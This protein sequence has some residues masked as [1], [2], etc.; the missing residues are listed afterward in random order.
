M[1]PSCPFRLII[2][3][4]SPLHLRDHLV[5]CI[6]VSRVVCDWLLVL[7]NLA[8]AWCALSC[9]C[10]LS[11]IRGSSSC[12]KNFAVIFGSAVLVSDCVPGHCVARSRLPRKNCR[13][14]RTCPKLLETTVVRG[15]ITTTRY[16]RRLWCLQ[17]RVTRRTKKVAR[18]SPQGLDFNSFRLLSC[19]ITAKDTEFSKESV[20]TRIMVS[21]SDVVL[22]ASLSLNF[23]SMS[24]PSARSQARVFLKAFWTRLQGTVVA[25]T[26]LL[27]PTTGYHKTRDSHVIQKRRSLFNASAR[28]QI[29]VL[30]RLGFF[31]NFFRTA[32]GKLSS[33]NTSAPSPQ[34]YIMRRGI[35]TTRLVQGH[36][37]KAAVSDDSVCTKILVS[38][39]CTSLVSM[40]CRTGGTQTALLVISEDLVSTPSDCGRAQSLQKKRRCMLHV[41][42]MH[43]A[44]VSQ[45]RTT[46][47][48]ALQK[49]VFGFL[50]CF[51]WAS[52][53]R[54]RDP[55]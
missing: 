32:C 8:Q 5:K 50:L 14:P 37:V 33:S 21:P 44:C 7:L 55:C 29:V 1:V 10:I 51:L 52:R 12:V 36:V 16:A 20:R 13:C 11:S 19:A 6:L 42:S 46:R 27:Q 2:P 24:C 22:R 30:M 23:E 3:H 9:S 48:H 26:V 47:S 39:S 49:S 40:F 41:I 53:R 43:E 35:P 38:P 45:P 25:K 18:I 28:T 4:V 31:Q 17:P 54:R 15:Q 34:M